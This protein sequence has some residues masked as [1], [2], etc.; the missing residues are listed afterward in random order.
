[1]PRVTRNGPCDDE[2]LQGLSNSIVQLVGA[3]PGVDSNSSF[4][5]QSVRLEL[6][7]GL[8]CDSDRG[9]QCVWADV[10]SEGCRRIG[11]Q[12]AFTDI[13]DGPAHDNEWCRVIH[14]GQFVRE[15]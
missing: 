3:V 7:R 5:F 11:L 4:A 13:F 14:H 12:H 8:E 1:M 6:C 9:N 15:L 2:R 10:F